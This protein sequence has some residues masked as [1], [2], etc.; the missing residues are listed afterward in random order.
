MSDDL[1][2]FYGARLDEDE[3][4]ALAVQAAAPG[5]WRAAGED[6]LTANPDPYWNGVCVANA[7]GE[8]AA[9]IVRHDPARVLRDV[10][11][12][13]KLLRLHAEVAEVADEAAVRIV[14]GI[15]ADQA[16]SWSDHL[17]YRLAWA[18]DPGMP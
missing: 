1:T 3:A 13:R 12:G 5:T 7:S 15:I 11:A 2:E 17:G 8:E 4:L 18:V 10:A 16:A 9:H 14:R 6:I